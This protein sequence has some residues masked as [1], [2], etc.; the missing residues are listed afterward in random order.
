MI[1]IIEVKY[2]RRIWKIP[3]NINEKQWT[4]GDKFKARGHGNKVFTIVKF[5]RDGSI[6]NAID[7]KK[8]EI[9]FSFS[10]SI[11]IKIETKPEVN[12]Y[13]PEIPYVYPEDFDWGQFELPCDYE[14]A[15]ILAKHLQIENIK[16]KD[17]KEVKLWIEIFKKGWLRNNETNKK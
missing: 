1:K 14:I 9:E 2:D 5:L 3:V 8:R 11:L 13:L 16:L 12:I 6:F 10:N 17:S 7:S 4:V 15:E